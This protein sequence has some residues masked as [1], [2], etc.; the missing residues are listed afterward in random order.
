MDIGGYYGIELEDTKAQSLSLYQ[1]VRDQFFSHMKP[2]KSRVYGIAGVTDMSAP[3]YV[4]GM[5]DI[6]T[7]DGSRLRILG[8]ST[9]GLRT[10]KIPAGL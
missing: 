1:T 7:Q 4:I 6:E 8:N 10:K 3:T 2:P 9:V 5:E